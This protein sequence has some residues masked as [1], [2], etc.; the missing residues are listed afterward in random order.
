MD[1]F[2]RAVV[3][4]KRFQVFAT[5]PGSGQN[6]VWLNLQLWREQGRNSNRNPYCDLSDTINRKSR[7]NRAFIRQ[8][9]VTEICNCV[10]SEPPASGDV[11]IIKLWTMS[12]S[13]SASDISSFGRNTEDNCCHWNCP[14]NQITFVEL[15]TATEELVLILWITKCFVLI[16]FIV[17]LFQ[18]F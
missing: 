6:G 5:A 4:L 8:I 1:L 7:G 2:K 11:W 18:A 12:Y 13:A 9:D 16:I 3:D 17:V 10:G 14:L 15:C